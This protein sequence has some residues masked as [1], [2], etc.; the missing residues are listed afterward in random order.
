M[1]YYT[2]GALLD[3]EMKY[4]KM[5]KWALALVIAAPKLKPYFHTY[6]VIVMTDQSWRQVL[7][8]P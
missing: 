2:S 1:L 6:L 3:P 7:H 4:L 8:K 5:E